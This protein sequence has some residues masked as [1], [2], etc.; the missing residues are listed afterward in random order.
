MP[1][2]II[3]HET[4]YRY[5]R[6]VGFG[7]QR[8]MLRPRDSHAVRLIHASLEL[9]QPGDN[10]WVYDALGNCVCWYTPRGEADQLTIVSNLTLDRFPSPVEPPRADDP[11]SAFPLVYDLHDRLALEPFIAPATADDGAALLGWLRG[12]LNSPTEPVFDFV[13]RLN[14]AIHAEF[15]YGERY[16]EG[17]QPPDVTLARGSGSCRDFAWLMVESLR[18]LGFAARFVTGYLYA[19]NIAARGSGAT[20]AWCEVFFPSLGWLEFDP[21][22]GL[23]ESPD[24][25]R[26]ATTRTPLEAAPVAGAIIGDPGQA[27]LTVSVDV[28]LAAETEPA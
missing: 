11:H 23:V 27:T 8:L 7:P 25:I 24:L 14:A 10:R 26:V 1:R 19:P 4:H 6:P 12:R 3:R 15:Q 17:A 28:Q 2:L 21:T 22:N 9:S 16:E 20:H 13:Q 18:R 5:Q